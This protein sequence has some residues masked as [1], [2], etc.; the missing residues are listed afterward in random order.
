MEIIITL[1][2][3][4]EK[5][6]DWKQFCEEEGFS[7]NCVEQGLANITLHVTKQDCFKYG[8]IKPYE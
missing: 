2:E 3:I 1:E 5:C 6:N 7:V 8:L 4:K